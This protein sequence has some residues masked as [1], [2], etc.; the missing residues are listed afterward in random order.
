MLGEIHCELLNGSS[1][2]HPLDA[3]NLRLQAAIVH[4]R[5]VLGVVAFQGV[6]CI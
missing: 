1:L 6:S 2:D 5:V 3:Q 4:V